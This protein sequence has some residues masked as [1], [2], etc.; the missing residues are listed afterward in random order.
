MSERVSVSREISASPET[1]YAMVSDLQRMGEWSPENQGGE[2]IGGARVRKRRA[3]GSAARNTVGSKSWKS[4]STVI[5]AQPGQRF[6]FRCKA[7]PV[8]LSEWSYAFE[9]TPAGC[10]V[11]ESWIDLRPAWFKPIASLAT[12]VSDRPTHNRRCMEE[13]L[14]RLE[15]AAEAEKEA[16]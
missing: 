12:G 6:S 13:T 14:E 5:D 10:R 8:T 1:L 7:G 2:W 4:V 11:T 9:A 3:R 15:A 16:G